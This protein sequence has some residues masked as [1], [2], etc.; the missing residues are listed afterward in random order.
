METEIQGSEF[1][2]SGNTKHVWNN[3]KIGHAKCTQS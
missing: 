2:L 1:H 3:L